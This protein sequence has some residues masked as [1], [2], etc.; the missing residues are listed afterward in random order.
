MHSA[1]CNLGLLD[2]F[3]DALRMLPTSNS[4]SLMTRHVVCMG[5][6]LNGMSFEQLQ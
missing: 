3:V 5:L 2:M 4:V 1:V 6:V